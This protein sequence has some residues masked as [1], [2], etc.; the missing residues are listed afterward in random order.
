M[1]DMIS[2]IGVRL[3]G[4]DGVIIDFSDGTTAAYVVEELLDLRPFRESTTFSS[5]I[6]DPERP[7]R[8]ILHKP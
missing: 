7:K 3:D 8:S 4:V 2:L 6:S 1:D 5:R